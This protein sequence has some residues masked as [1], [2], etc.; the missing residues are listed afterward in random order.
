MEHAGFRSAPNALTHLANQTKKAAPRGGFFDQQRITWLVQLEQQV[1]LEQLRQRQEQRQ[2][3]RRQQL[4][5]E[6]QRVLVLVL[7]LLFYRKQP[8]RKLQRSLPRRV[9]CS[10]FDTLINIRKQFSKK[11]N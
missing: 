3:Q 2:E 4:V 8:G 9:I 5:Q 7:V 10:F 1:Q 11:P 6:Q